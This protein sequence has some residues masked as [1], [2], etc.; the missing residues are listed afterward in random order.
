MLSLPETFEKYKEEIYLV[1]FRIINGTTGSLPNP[2][3]NPPISSLFKTLVKTSLWGDILSKGDFDFEK[4]ISTNVIKKTKPYLL[5]KDETIWFLLLTTLYFTLK[6]KQDNIDRDISF[7]SGFMIMMKY[8]TSLSN[9][10][11]SKFCDKTK[12]ILAL[13][14][15]SDKALFSSKNVQVSQKAK[16]ILNGYSLNAKIKNDI[17]NFPVTLGMVYIFNLV[18]ENYFQKITDLEDINKI[19]DLITIIRSRVSQSFKAYAQHYYDLVNVKI[20]ADSE[21]ETLVNNAINQVINS[22]SQR[23]TYIPD[24]HFRIIMQLTSVPVDGLK[25]MYDA[26]YKTPDNQSLVSNIVNIFLHDD[27]YQM[28]IKSESLME[29]LSIVKGVVSIRTKYDIRG[30]LLQVIQSS[31]P[32]L[33]AYEEK[34]DSFKHKMIQAMGMV[35]GLSIYDT[36][37]SYNISR[38]MHNMII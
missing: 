35:I 21:N 11:M 14:T 23:M 20:S 36:L 29:W 1:L 34:S 7:L 37:K 22:N 16:S 30:M 27:R 6:K 33:K 10:H 4:Y 8:Y 13:D 15:L 9:K 18:Q 2:C 28:L 12:A 3:Y 25:L 38:V 31:E 19:S 17:K 24:D 32:I 26:L 5:F